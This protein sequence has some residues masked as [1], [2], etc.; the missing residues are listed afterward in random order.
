MTVHGIDLDPVAISI[1]CRKWKIKELS[2]FGSV[3]RD[4]CRPE[5]DHDFLVDFARCPQVDGYDL[6][7]EMRM[8]EELS[9]VV[10]RQVDLV[11]KSVLESNSNP[12]I[13]AE[14]LSTAET[15]YAER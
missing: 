11:D 6:F 9:F 3:L 2:L 10:G 12:F 8:R 7:D 15:V 4:D 1:F 5:S 13:P 14:L